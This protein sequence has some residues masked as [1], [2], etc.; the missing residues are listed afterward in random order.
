[1]G[2]QRS[3]GASPSPTAWVRASRAAM[4]GSPGP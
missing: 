4:V 2:G 3:G 1:M